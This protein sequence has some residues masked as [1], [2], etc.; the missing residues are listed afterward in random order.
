MCSKCQRVLDRDVGR[1]L[2]IF[3]VFL[4]FL[5]MTDACWLLG[6]LFCLD[7]VCDFASSFPHSSRSIL[8][9]HMPRGPDM[10]QEEI[11]SLSLEKKG[12]L[13]KP[14]QGLPL[15]PFLYLV[16]GPLSSSSHLD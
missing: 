6:N 14:Q 10:Q 7:A 4:V 5:V 3:F 15:T 11:K 16:K 8:R 2:S 9:I 13:F 1:R 12:D